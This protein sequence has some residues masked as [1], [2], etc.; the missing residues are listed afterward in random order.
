MKEFI[1]DEAYKQICINFEGSIEISGLSGQDAIKINRDAKSANM[2]SK[3]YGDCVL[4]D[5]GANCAIIKDGKL[6]VLLNPEDYPVEAI[7][8][9]IKGV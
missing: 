4:I 8:I 1:I 6:T 7:V 5:V 2:Q 9:N 3:I